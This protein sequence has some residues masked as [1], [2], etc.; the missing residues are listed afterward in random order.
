MNK[1]GDDTCQ[2][3][4]QIGT[5]KMKFPENDIKDGLPAACVLDGFFVKP[6][7][8]Y[9]RIKLRYAEIIWIE[10]ENNYSHI[11]R[12]K[13]HISVSFNIQHVMDILP[14]NLFMRINRSEIVNMYH[15]SKYY[16][17]TIY[18]D[19]C[20]KSFVVGKTFREQVFK[21]FYELK[22]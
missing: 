9:M 7:G 8:E 22:K 19:D 5:D 1:S 14:K 6:I 18:L 20:T 21:C 12:S 13:G 2:E 11:H 17:N 16:G 10:A 4:D 15:I 3:T